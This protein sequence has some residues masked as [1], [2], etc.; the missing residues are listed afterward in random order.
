MYIIRKFFSFEAAHKLSGLRKGHKCGTL[1][2]HTYG[3][4]VELQ[5]ATLDRRGFVRDYGDLK[6]LK[7]HIDIYLD[8][9]YLNE[10]AEKKGFELLRQPTAENIAHYLYDWC[11][12]RW[13]EVSAVV[14][15]ETQATTAEYRPV[16]SQWQ[17]AS[18]AFG[19]FIAAYSKGDDEASA[20]ALKKIE[21]ALRS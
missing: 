20:A 14:V 17:V 5:S 19:E 13:P 16:V 9:S 18:A 15:S 7:T 21:R 10:V 3:V 4:T 11:A 6:A 8:H 12:R 2:G 1:H